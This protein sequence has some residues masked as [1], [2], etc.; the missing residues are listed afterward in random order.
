MRAVLELK[1][2]TLRVGPSHAEQ[3][4]LDTLSLRF[5][6]G[7]CSAILGPSGSGKST[8]LKVIAGILP[9]QE[10]HIYW[11]GQNLAE[12]E[13]PPGDIGYVPQF[14]IA[15]EF[16]TVRENLDLTLRLRVAGLSR[17]ERNERR[18]HLLDITGLSRLADRQV[19]L[20]SGGEQRRLGLALELTSNPR[21]LLCDEVTSGLD[22]LAEEEIVGLMTHLAREEERQ[23]ITVTHSLRHLDLYES[24]AVIHQGRIAYCGPPDGLLSHFGVEHAEDVFPCLAHADIPVWQGTEEPEQPA[25][26]VDSPPPARAPIPSAIRQFFALFEGRMRVFLRDRSH[27]WM[28]LALLLGFPCLV[29]VFAHRGLPQ[30]R[31]LSMDLDQSVIEQ[32][33]DNLVWLTQSFSVGTLVSGIVMFQVILLALM[34]SNNAAREIAGERRLLEKEKLAGLHPGAY[35]SARACFLLLLVAAQSVWMGVFVDTFCRLPGSLGMQILMLFLVN[36]ALTSTCLAISS[37]LRSPEQASLFSIYLVGFQLPLSGAVLAL[38]DPL[39][40]LTRPFIAAYW[41]WSGILQTLRDSRLYDVVQQVTQT[42]IA[43]GAVCIWAL[44]CHIL[45]GLFVAYAGCRMHREV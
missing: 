7:R 27:A 40:T 9:H 12:E 37:L 29:V 3:T 8:L 36:G 4:L 20:L 18:D 5:P 13:P 41:S 16:L 28:Q 45:L 33:Q 23:I 26:D 35:V 10:G 24:V 22:P 25:Q 44:L 42:E 31:N 19:R 43:P 2:I 17:E 39:S 1:D 21:L 30:I 11:H 14:M 38:P 32:L 6:A 34:G 15:Q